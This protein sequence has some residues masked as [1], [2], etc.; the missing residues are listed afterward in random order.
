MGDVSSLAGF[1][2]PIAFDGPREDDGWL[3][4]VFDGGLQG[5][6]VSRISPGSSLAKT[7]PAHGKK[8]IDGKATAYI[9]Q[10]P[11]C[12][13]PIID[14]PALREELSRI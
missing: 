3:S 14:V 4:L 5:R 11:V 8:Q 13:L 12:G 2:Q 6:L 1:A 10:G 7:H 9:C